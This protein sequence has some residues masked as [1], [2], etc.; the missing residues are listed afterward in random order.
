MLDTDG[1]TGIPDYLDLDS[2]NDGIA[3][4][5]EVA[6]HLDGDGLVDKFIN[7]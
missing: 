6:V 2:H 1:L 5:V 4:I 7:R 3:D